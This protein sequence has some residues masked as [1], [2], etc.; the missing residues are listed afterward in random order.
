MIY[1]ASLAVQTKK[2]FANKCKQS[3]I[4]RITELLPL[5]PSLSD[6][7]VVILS[8]RDL[9]GGGAAK[10]QAAIDT[11]HPEVCVI[12]FASND[13]ESK[14]LTG[15]HTQVGSA[16]AE[17]VAKAVKEFFG[18]QV[19]AT[20]FEELSSVY[21]KTPDKEP[22][23]KPVI[24]PAPIVEE[25]IPEPVS[26][27]AP[28]PVVIPE[29]PAIEPVK[30]VYTAPAVPKETIEDKIKNIKDFHDWDYFMQ[31]LK[32]DTITRELLVES[33]DYQGVRAM[34][35]VWDSRIREVFGN[36]RLSDAEKYETLKKFG[37][38]RTMLKAS[39]NNLY[40]EKLCSIMNAIFSSVE[41]TMN[42]YMADTNERINNIRV[43]REG[44]LAA[45]NLDDLFEE[46]ALLV[47]DLEEKFKSL[48]TVYQALDASAEETIKNF[49][50]G[51]PSENKYI[52][53][54]LDETGRDFLPENIGALTSAILYS[55]QEG[56][57]KA[58]GLALS[59]NAAI[60]AVF[61]L[62]EKDG[63]IVS[64]QKK[65]ND[66]L[67]ANRV[68]DVVLRDSLIKDVMH[69]FVGSKNSGKTA[70]ALAWAGTMSRKANTLFVDITP[71]STAERYGVHFMSV[72]DFTKTTPK[73]NF[74]AIRANVGTNME[75]TYELMKAL[76]ESITY[77]SCMVV[78]ADCS[79]VDVINQLSED[80]LTLT[81][82]TDC[83]T[84]SMTAIKDA[85]PQYTYPNIAHRLAAIHSPITFAEL[86]TALGFELMTT[87]II[88]I[89]YMNEIRL[90]CL[91]HFMPHEDI[92]VA[93][94]IEE[95]FS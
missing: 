52:N 5:D 67:V 56:N 8:S 30:V 22:R 19:R 71:D 35:D 53:Q 39:E 75:Q 81:C 27:P 70:T 20:T 26:E 64:Y 58:D 3:S 93:T 13:K 51:L 55:L 68:E 91:R 16:S 60:A 14:L 37:Q 73:A 72:E 74:V 59:I 2:A 40:S 28:E 79:Q 32:K 61:K 38:E 7:D 77:Y 92:S 41:F 45:S 80:A 17:A 88:P 95:A 1:S 34:L 62:S 86:G 57:V 6:M 87:K 66:L 44:F 11:K 15:V 76:R 49:Q 63:E 82:V 24:K 83:S 18:E 21:E 12:Y 4:K 47:L 43:D 33:T 48:V 90:A 9:A 36:P 46:R 54:I 25:A 78:L 94:I 23:A 31:S 10:M 29:M 89:P 69:L 65:W 85:L 84:E 42:S 50:T